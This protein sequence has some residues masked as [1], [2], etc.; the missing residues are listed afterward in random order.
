MNLLLYSSP[1]L[2][3]SILVSEGGEGEKGEEPLPQPSLIPLSYPEPPYRPPG[4]K[5]KGKRG[6]GREK[7]RHVDSDAS[8][9]IS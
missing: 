5:R 9:C 3:G 7:R 6:G 8:Y 2:R 4:A 1:P